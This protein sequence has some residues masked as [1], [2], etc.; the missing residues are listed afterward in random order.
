MRELRDELVALPSCKG[1]S[2]PQLL[3]IREALAA[4]SMTIY[5]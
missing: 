5:E 2:N 1:P 4:L 3:G